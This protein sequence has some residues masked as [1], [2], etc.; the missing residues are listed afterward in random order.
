MVFG[1]DVLDLD[2]WV[3]V[4]SIEQPIKRNSVGPG[5]MSHCGTPSLDNH[6]DHCFVVLATKRLDAKTGRFKE[7]NQYY[8][9]RW[10]S[11]EI[12]WLL[13]MITDRTGLSVVWVKFPKTE[14]IRSHNSRARSPSNLN[15]ASK[16]MISDS[17]EL[18]ET[19]VCFLH[20][21]LIGTNVWLPKTHNVPPEV[22][23]DSSRS[24]LQCYPHNDIVCIHM[25]D[26]C[27]KS[28]DSSVCHKLW[29]ILW[30]IV[31]VCSLT[32]EYQA[33]QFVPNINILEQFESILVTILQKISFILLWSGGHR[34]M[35]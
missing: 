20:I 34:C 28:I 2:F 33:F 5:N 9:A 21:Q 15:P 23:F 13:S 26:E 24:V 27:M 6:L 1:V 22:D 8:S 12:F 4:N 16:E 30:W 29:S 3:Q 17:V 19:E 31:Q 35:E 25:Y 14:I 11:L 18:C 10:S 7:H 32:I